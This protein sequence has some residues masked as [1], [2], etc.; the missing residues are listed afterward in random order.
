MN[1][2]E[3]GEHKDPTNF[4]LGIF[5]MLTKCRPFATAFVL[6]LLTITLFKLI[7]VDWLELTQ[8]TALFMGL[9]LSM[10]CAAL[11]LKL[12]RRW[13][14]EA[15][16]ADRE[17]QRREQADSN[18]VMYLPQVRAASDLVPIVLVLADSRKASR[19]LVVGG[20]GGYMDS[21]GGEVWRDGISEWVNS[22]VSV[23][24]VLMQPP[25][26]TVAQVLLALVSNLGQERFQVHVLPA[27]APQDNLIAELTTMH[28]ALIYGESRNGEKP[29]PAALWL[30]GNHPN[31]T[32]V[33]ED[34]LYVPPAAMERNR[35]MAKLFEHCEEAVEKVIHQCSSLQ[36]A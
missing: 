30:E 11:Y 18:E 14:E 24:Y 7:V 22:G 1:A 29:S 32:I 9:L 12:T 4:T 3:F 6:L 23:V 25:T 31:G 8:Q 33:A 10:A 13:H 34:V 19:V 28:P 2:G 36:A 17:Q 21:E 27:D 5:A 35:E 20:D 26:E 15:I 16:R